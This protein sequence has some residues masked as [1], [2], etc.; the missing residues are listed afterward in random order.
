M[1]VFVRLDKRAK[2]QYTENKHLREEN[3]DE[4]LLLHA[5]RRAPG[6]FIP[7]R[8]LSAVCHAKAKE[9]AA[10][11]KALRT[12]GYAVR[13]LPWLGYCLPL[14]A[15]GVSRRAF[16]KEIAGKLPL[17]LRVV[18]HIGSTNAYLKARATRSPA[19][20]ALC[21]GYQSAGRGRLGR[22]FFS[23]PA[24]G[25]YASFLLY[26]DFPALMIPQIT[27]AA[28]VAICE[29]TE[30]VLGISPGIKWVND[31]YW[32]QKK[33]CGILSESVPLPNGKTAVVLGFGCN[34]APPPDGYP[35]ELRAIAG[36]LLEELPPPRVQAAL[37]AKIGERFFAYYTSL[38]RYTH[39]APYRARC[40]LTGQR[41]S[42]LCGQT[43][44]E[45]TVCGIDEHAALLLRHDD[46]TVRAYACGEISLHGGLFGQQSDKTEPS[47]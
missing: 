14:R 6:H 32:K 1:I 16:Q 37:L 43:R 47:V 45:A 44:R 34:L 17:H 26:P 39:I 11:K 8:E 4:N 7:V 3:M 29:A 46:G 12:A 10:A 41:V 24:C 18:H 21:A 15:C 36:A 31:L 2:T 40:F 25:M 35:E 28:A 9:L 19:T 33:V 13:H 5:L 20:N 30:A 22:A 42:Y 23:P 38:P 27:V